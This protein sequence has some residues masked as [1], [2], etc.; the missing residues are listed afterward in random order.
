MVGIL[1]VF[2][3]G[4]LFFAAA[5]FSSASLFWLSIMSFISASTVGFLGSVTKPNSWH[6]DQETVWLAFCAVSIVVNI[7]AIMIGH[8]IV[9]AAAARIA[10][11]R[12]ALKSG[13]YFER[14][15]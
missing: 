5:L 6:Q 15:R 12:E 10:L 4:A 8:G 7:M 11:Q 1:A 13:L 14:D 2:I 3:V 9:R